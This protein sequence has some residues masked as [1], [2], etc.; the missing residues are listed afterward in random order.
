M[1]LERRV[2]S[3]DFTS[4][5]LC[6]VNKKVISGRE[7][8]TKKTTTCMIGEASRSTQCGDA[9]SFCATLTRNRA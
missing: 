9:H 7:K 3:T 8:K 2:F 1:N 6:T 4:T 5:Y